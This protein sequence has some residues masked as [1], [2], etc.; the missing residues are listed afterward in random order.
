MHYAIL[1]NLY[2][3]RRLGVNPRKLVRMDDTGLPASIEIAW[4]LRD[5]PSKGPKPGLSLERIVGAAV[6]IAASE[7]L[8]AV[9]MGKVAAE[10]GVGTMSL[11]RYVGAK[12]ELLVLMAEAAFATPPPP[13]TPGEGW[14]EGLSR[15]AWRLFEVMRAN[16][17]VLRMP[18]TGPPATPNQLAW[19]ESGLVALRGSGLSESAKMSVMLLL[20]G[21]VRAEATVSTEIGVAYAARG[22]TE[23]QGAA[24]YGRLLARLVTP[25]RYPAITAAMAAGVATEEDSPE[26]RFEFGLTRLLDG[27]ESLVHDQ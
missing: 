4:G 25:E 17:W 1:R 6:R 10:L 20:V 22:E 8:A 16:A 5:R 21:F 26:R 2:A 23:Q 12:D 11:Y 19:L 24:A 14:R 9:S 15:W 3:V 27:I 7:G 18:I 13:P